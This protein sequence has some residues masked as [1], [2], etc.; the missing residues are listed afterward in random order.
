MNF[1]RY[2]QSLSYCSNYVYSYN[3]KVAIIEDGKLVVNNWYSVTTSK[4]VSYAAR[5][6]NL[7]VVKNY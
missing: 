5:E 4:H 3:T 7:K 6:L 1:K 2:K